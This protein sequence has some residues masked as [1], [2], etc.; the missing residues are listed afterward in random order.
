M[1]KLGLGVMIGQLGGNSETV[2]AYHNS[3]GK[4]IDKVCLKD[5]ELVFTFADG[6]R[7]TA[8]DDGQSC[9]ERRYMTTDDDLSYY[10]GAILQKIEV[11]EGPDVDEEYDVHEIEF[12]EIETS[13]GS[14]QMAN[15]NEHNGYYGGFH[16]VL[17]HKPS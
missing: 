11:K 13:K 1:S 16:V 14:F 12:L 8:M 15:H 7:L 4:V 2:D 10:S 6:S 3:I 9:C 5:D 17:R